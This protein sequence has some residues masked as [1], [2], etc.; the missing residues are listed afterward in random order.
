[1]SMES[2]KVFIE[3]M[4]ADE[5]FTKKNNAEEAGQSTGELTDEELEKVAGGAVD[6]EGL[7]DMI[8]K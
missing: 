7:G 6:R 2:T 4:K 1:M 8:K 5:D 3:R